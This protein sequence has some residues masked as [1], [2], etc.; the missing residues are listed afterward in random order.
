[1]YKNEVILGNLNNFSFYINFENKSTYNIGKC[2]RLASIGT[3]W[4]KPPLS[5]QA[6]IRPPAMVT[7]PAHTGPHWRAPLEMIWCGVCFM[8]SFGCSFSRWRKVGLPL[9]LWQESRPNFK[10]LPKVSGVATNHWVLLR[11]DWS[12]V[13]S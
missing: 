5:S 10:G 1:M 11:C 7:T 2:Q 3:G 9:V 13:S 12:P 8:Q 4:K 6:L